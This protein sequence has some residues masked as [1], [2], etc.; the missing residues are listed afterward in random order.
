MRERDR[1]W[2]REWKRM[3]W[4][5]TIR[6][7]IMNFGVRGCFVLYPSA[8]NLFVQWIF[9]LPPL[10][11]LYEW[12]TMPKRNGLFATSTQRLPSDRFRFWR[13]RLSSFFVLLFFL[14]QAIVVYK[15][16]KITNTCIV[17]LFKGIRPITLNSTHQI[18][19]Q[20]Q[21]RE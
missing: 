1:Q 19:Q 13:A 20:Q 8:T 9:A 7:F 4:T 2:V 16:A 3:N 18:L 14:F 15:S 21:K 10:L 5:L 17:N 6:C 11:L 12:V